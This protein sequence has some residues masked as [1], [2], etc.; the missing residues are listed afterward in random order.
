MRITLLIAAFCST[1]FMA[2]CAKK[3]PAAGSQKDSIT[4]LYSEFHDFESVADARVD[5]SKGF[6]GKV[7]GVL[8]GQIEYGFGLGK[9]LKELPSYKSIEE[10]SI[11]FNCLMDKAYPD[12]VFVISIDDTIAKK[13]VMWEGKSITP[14]K[15]GEWSPV[16]ISYRIS[17]DF[18]NPEYIL[19]LYIWN[20]GKNTFYFD[21]LS[22]TFQK[23][24]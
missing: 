22:F 19:K 5:S 7:C 20:K 13:N 10:V 15:F 3:K 1:L 14:A 4:V 12:D 8:N 2:S 11:S 23:K 9:Q 17:K 18:L 16:N 21:D 6:S 24:K